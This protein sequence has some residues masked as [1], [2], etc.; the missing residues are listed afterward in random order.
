MPEGFE[1]DKDA[2][3]QRGNIGGWRRVAY[4]EKL[5]HPVFTLFH[6][7][8]SCLASSALSIR[9]F[10]MQTAT[11]AFDHFNE[12]QDA[13]C[14]ERIRAAREKLGRKAVLLCHLTTSAPTSINTPT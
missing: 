12:P 11:I 14:H 10:A 3:D 5:T 6:H 9:D 7:G 13:A 8:D 2:N 4:R 1:G